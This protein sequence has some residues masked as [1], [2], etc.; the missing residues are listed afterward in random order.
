ML[1][2][3]RKRLLYR[4][5]RHTI[6]SDH[7]PFFPIFIKNPCRCFQFPVASMPRLVSSTTSQLILSEAKRQKFVCFISAMK[8]ITKRIPS[9]NRSKTTIFDR[10]NTEKT[11]CT[12]QSILVQYDT[13]YGHCL[14]INN[15]FPCLTKDKNY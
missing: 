12:D 8:F 6:K 2:P 9:K 7:A 1:F 15:I 10:K 13:F 5:S 14:T 4:L 11:I 3:S